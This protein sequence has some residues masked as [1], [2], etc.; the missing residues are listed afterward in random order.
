[1][2]KRTLAV[3]LC[4]CVCVSLYAGISTVGAEEVTAKYSAD[5]LIEKTTAE[6]TYDYFLLNK[7]YE[8]GK[9]VDSPA[10][11]GRGSRPS[12]RTSG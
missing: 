3:I 7:A 8:A 10:L 6:D 2:I 11:S 4:C 1:M 5:A 12:G 9:R